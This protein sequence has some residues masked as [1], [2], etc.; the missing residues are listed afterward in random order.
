MQKNKKRK[1]SKLAQGL[2]ESRK[3][4]R[5]N[6]FKKLRFVQLQQERE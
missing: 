3:M 4:R 1:R 5:E 2:F 6:V